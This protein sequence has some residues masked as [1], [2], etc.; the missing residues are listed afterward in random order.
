MSS[1]ILF[2]DVQNGAAASLGIEADL[3]WPLRLRSA[4]AGSVISPSKIVLGSASAGE[5]GKRRRGAEGSASSYDSYSVNDRRHMPSNNE[6][7]RR[8]YENNI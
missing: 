3:F 6:K 1:N 7:E 4:A 5:H 8:R 2:T